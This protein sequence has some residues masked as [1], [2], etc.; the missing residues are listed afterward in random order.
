MP[1]LPFSPT[2]ALRRYMS[3]LRDAVM[4]VLIS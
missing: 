2:Q 3:M 4:L 1:S